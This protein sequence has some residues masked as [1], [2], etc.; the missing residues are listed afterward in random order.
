MHK[1]ATNHVSRHEHQ[2]HNI[3]RAAHAFLTSTI[4]FNTFGRFRPFFF[5]DFFIFFIQ[6]TCFVAHKK[7]KYKSYFDDEDHS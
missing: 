5:A 7:K 1:C 6:R 4:F 3:D 2:H